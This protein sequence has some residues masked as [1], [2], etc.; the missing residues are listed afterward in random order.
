[1]TS[2]R[3]FLWRP[4]VAPQ[5]WTYP[6]RRLAATS[7]HST[8]QALASLAQ[9]LAVPPAPPTHRIPA[10]LEFYADASAPEGA[11]YLD[12]QLVGYLPGVRRL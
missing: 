2:P 1:M 7:L 10:V 3:I 8:S 6:L 5:P 11:L 9:S 12:G 4:E